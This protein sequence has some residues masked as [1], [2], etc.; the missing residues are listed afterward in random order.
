M[1]Y[2]KQFLVL[3]VFG[4]TLIGFSQTKKL[5]K[6]AEISFI[7]A[8]PGKVLYEGF[9]HSTIRI[10]DASQALDLAYNY[11]IFDFDAPNFYTNFAKGKLAYKLFSYPFHYFVKSYKND[12]RWIKEQI[13]NLTHKEKQQFYE[14][15]EN[16]A[17]PENATYLYDP[18]YNNC[19]TK[20]RDITLLVLKDKVTFNSDH[21]LKK[22]SLRTLM[23]AEINWNTLASYGLNITLGSKLDQIAEPHQ[24]MY[25]PDYV[26]KGFNNA[27]IDN[28]NAVEKLIKKDHFIL[29]YSEKQIRTSFL[30]PIV[31]FSFL[32]LIGL[33]ITYREI[34]SNKKV[35]W[36]D[37]FL[38]FTTGITG[39]LILFL[40]FFTDHST[41][42]N[43]YNFLWAFAPNMVVAFY[44]RKNW[45]ARYVRLLL[46]FLLFIPIIW[47]IDI[48][49]FS[50]ALIPLL[51]LLIVRYL[52]LS[53]LLSSQK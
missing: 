26:Y 16:N 37:A 21:I 52:S 48:Q 14:Y 11:G 22:K 38:F 24:Y 13:L 8:G 19:A 50:L 18:F 2:K 30:N 42:P 39:I 7:T 34:K 51:L 17:K 27:T 32:L 53:K 43:N 3:F 10:Q 6:I 31:I 15:L 36:F 12:K 40:W 47:I 46:L 5:S 28:G 25:L 44:I 9:G 29:N 33:F 35:T 1:I 4:F 45:I 20:L 41:T 49:H 23:H